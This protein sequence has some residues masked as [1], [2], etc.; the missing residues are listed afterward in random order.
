MTSPI[1]VDDVGLDA[2]GRLVED[3]ELRLERQRAPD[4][5]LLLLAAREIAAAPLEHLFSTGN[6]VEDAFAGMS[7]AAPV[8]REPDAQVLLDGRG[9]AK[10]S[11][12]CGT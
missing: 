8:G 3:Q 10:I 12:P 11:R 9:A 6:S 1:S 7:R 2:L 5:Q 4:G